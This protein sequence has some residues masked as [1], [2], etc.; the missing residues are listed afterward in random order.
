MIVKFE[1]H[2]DIDAPPE[3]VWAVISD[4]NTWPQWFP[5]IEQIS[6]LGTLATGSSFSWQKGAESG[7]G[8][9]VHVD[10]N[11]LKVVTTIGDNQ[12]THTYTIGRHG[13]LFGMGGHDTR[14]TYRMEYDPPG[15]LLGDFVASGN[16]ADILR[17]KHTLEKVKHLAEGR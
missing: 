11:D 2:T 4:P 1:Q 5:E 17:V 12:V 15:G 6:G 10:E 8:A 16:P 9:I 14:L 13:G 3:T 7:S